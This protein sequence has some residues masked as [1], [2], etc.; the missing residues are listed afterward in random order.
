M[1]DVTFEVDYSSEMLTILVDGKCVFGG[2]FWDF[3]RPGDIVGLVK[4]LGHVVEVVE[5]YEDD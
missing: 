1:S 2:N 4:S 3:N 5:K